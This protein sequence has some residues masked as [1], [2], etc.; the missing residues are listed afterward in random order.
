MKLVMLVQKASSH[1]DDN[2]TYLYT[3]LVRCSL[4][5]VVLLVV[6]GC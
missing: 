6:A 3:V 5:L 2:K 4:L 1:K